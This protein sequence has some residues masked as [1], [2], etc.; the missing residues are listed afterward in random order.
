MLTQ[1]LMLEQEGVPIRRGRIQRLE[2]HRW[3]GTR[4]AKP[5]RGSSGRTPADERHRA[6][7]ASGAPASPARRDGR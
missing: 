1:R 7:R 3:T 4:R 2:R 5:A 6:L